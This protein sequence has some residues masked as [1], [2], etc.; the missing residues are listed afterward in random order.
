MTTPSAFLA[1]Q[2]DALLQETRPPSMKQRLKDSMDSLLTGFIALFAAICSFIELGLSTTFPRGIS[3]LVGAFLILFAGISFYLTYFTQD[4]ERKQRRRYIMALNEKLR[5][6]KQPADFKR[7]F[8][9]PA[10][11]TPTSRN[12]EWRNVPNNL[13][14]NGDIVALQSGQLAPCDVIRLDDGRRTKRDEKIGAP[15]TKLYH[16][17]DESKEEN[18]TK[19]SDALP[20][21]LKLM[22]VELYQVQA[23]PLIE[24]LKIFLATQEFETQLGTQLRYSSLIS[25][26]VAFIAFVIF[27]L[28]VGILHLVVYPNSYSMGLNFAEVILTRSATLLC[29][30][31]P[32]SWSW[33]R[34]GLELYWANRL[35]KKSNTV[36]NDGYPLAPWNL[37]RLMGSITT[38]CN[39]DEETLLTPSAGCEE[40]FLLKGEKK[41]K[42]IDLCLDENEVTGLRFEDPQWRTH[43]RSLKP[44]GLGCMLSGLT[45]SLPEKE[46]LSDTHQEK[47]T[48]LEI[49]QRKNEPYHLTQFAMTM[50][51]RK[52]EYIQS[53]QVKARCTILKEEDNESEFISHRSAS[54]FH[55]KPIA[56]CLVV[57]I[58]ECTKEHQPNI[59]PVS[60]FSANTQLSTQPNNSALQSQNQPGIYH[61][62]CWGHPSILLGFCTEYWDGES[63]WSLETDTRA[64]IDNIK[65][66]WEK[67]DF[68][69]IVCCY[70]PMTGLSPAAFA[71]ENDFFVILPEYNSKN[72]RDRDHHDEYYLQSHS[73]SSHRSNNLISSAKSSEDIR[74]MERL[75]NRTRSFNESEHYGLKSNTSRRFSSHQNSPTSSAAKTMP[76]SVDAISSHLNRGLIFTGI[77]GSRDQPMLEAASM[78]ETLWQCGIRFVYFS[79]RNTI[80]SRKIAEKLGLET[81]WNTSI[82]LDEESKTTQVSN[83]SY[84]DWESKTHMPRG[85]KAIQDHIRHVDDVPLRVSVFTDST[86][87]K[88][89]EMV[90]LIRENREIVFVF[91]NPLG[92]CNLKSFM[93]AN[94]SIACIL[95]CKDDCGEE[96][97]RELEVS[98]DFGKIACSFAFSEHQNEVLLSLLG[99]GRVALY[100]YQQAN[101][102]FICLGIIAFIGQIVSFC[103][104]VGAMFTLGNCLWLVI[105]QIPLISLSPA[106]RPRSRQEVLKKRMP[107]KKTSLPDEKFKAFRFLIYAVVRLA[108]CILYLIGIYLWAFLSLTDFDWNM[109]WSSDNYYNETIQEYNIVAQTVTLISFVWMS[110]FVSFTFASRMHSGK[111]L[112]LSFFVIWASLTFFAVSLQIVYNCIFTVIVFNQCFIHYENLTFVLWLVLFLTPPIFVPLFAFPVKKH[113]A[114]YYSRSMQMLRLDFETKLGQF[115]PK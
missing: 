54:Y 32:L 5:H 80:K 38:L 46:K 8:Y 19:N 7:S 72:E 33:F 58:S 55:R 70:G 100:N 110:C 53:F 83:A 104:N 101:Q 114:K 14:I 93:N 61:L 66:Q 85:I 84:A 90:S 91:G 27:G 22:N 99:E 6:L 23:S 16:D 76:F 28:I 87:T 95:E 40:V 109:S 13:L 108:P 82:S 11:Q 88:V 79:P 74:L 56:E 17:L 92:G 25:R 50:G 115:S 1:S 103:T 102:T 65:R 43:L 57:E 105:V 45:K 86:P 47:D 21:F 37:I 4:F 9:I 111:G 68:D 3:G 94:V 35:T 63:I 107:W 26:L 30:L 64:Q 2:I 77:I 60:S 49:F 96:Q 18:K 73:N 112:E 31:P 97:K 51:F 69:S 48:L 29:F 15:L 81:D 89:S 10:Y 36:L 113:D 67:E 34:F 20:S 71:D 78:V 62:L 42:V 41:T 75:P 52:D 106:L 39:L 59:N 24:D 12:G 98:A 44:L